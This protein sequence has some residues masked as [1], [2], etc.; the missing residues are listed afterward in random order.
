MRENEAKVQVEWGPEY[1]K[2]PSSADVS[3]FVPPTLTIPFPPLYD[4]KLVVFVF[5]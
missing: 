1:E 2:P 5:V 3:E 4:K